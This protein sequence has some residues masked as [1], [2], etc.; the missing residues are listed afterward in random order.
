MLIGATTLRSIWESVQQQAQVGR[1]ALET[2]DFVDWPIWM[3]FLSVPVALVSLRILVPFALD[4][5]GMVFGIAR[6]I[7]REIPGTIID[8]ARLSAW[9][10]DRYADPTMGPEDRDMWMSRTGRFSDD[11]AERARWYNREGEYSE[12]RQ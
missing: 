1:D 9:G 11:P 10:R 3:V 5:I 6:G 8:V 7:R 2:K 12:D 4:M